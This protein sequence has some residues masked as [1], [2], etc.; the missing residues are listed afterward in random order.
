M[1]SP[2]C[3]NKFLISTD[4]N[5]FDVDMIHQFLSER[6]YWATGVS[7]EVVKRSIKGSLC[8]GVFQD[9]KQVGFARVISDYAT[10]AYL[11]DVFILE[12]YRGNG[13]GKLMMQSIMDHPD[14]QNLRRWLLGTLDAHGLYR[15][16]GFRGLKAPERYMERRVEGRE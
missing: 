2:I 10:I 13:L 4:P 6:S 12:E 1:I 14:L 7:K 5:R 11:A 9:D 3:T 15:Q 8:F 16:Y